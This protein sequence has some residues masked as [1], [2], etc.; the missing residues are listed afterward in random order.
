MDTDTSDWNYIQLAQKHLDEA[1]RYH[2]TG[3]LEKAMA[4]CDEALGIDPG[5]AD[6]HNLRG[7]VLEEM[8][9]YRE[10]VRAYKQAVSFD[11]D[12]PEAQ[13]NLRTLQDRLQSVFDARGQELITIATFGG[14]GPAYLEKA[15]L[16][17]AGI[18][19]FVVTTTRI[20]GIAPGGA[21]LQVAEPDAPRAL[22]ILNGEPEDAS[23]TDAFYCT[24]CGRDVEADWETCP[25]CGDA[26]GETATEEAPLEFECPRCAKPVSD[27]W[28]VCP[29]CKE[30]LIELTGYACS[31]CGREVEEDWEECP[32]CGQLLDTTE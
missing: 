1:D 26:L 15:R 17:S 31:K 18:P 30:Q 28:E 16:E 6:G 29:H 14:E 25:N 27:S 2:E 13:E 20:S 32:H 21:Q 5:S 7:I 23:R 22:R 4:K 8:G 11:P 3:Q 24:K 10:A 9:R 19:A 12:F